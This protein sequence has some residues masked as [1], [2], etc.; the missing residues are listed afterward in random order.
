VSRLV[1]FAVAATL[2]VCAAVPAS[3]A[4]PISALQVE[5]RDRNNRRVRLSEFKGRIVVVDLWASWCPT[6]Q[7]TFPA[8]DAL[9]RTFRACG[10]EVVAVNLDERRQDAETFL[11]G[12]SPDM[13]VA[14]DPRA[15]VLKAFGA[16]GIPSLYIID[17]QGE[18]RHTLSGESP[19]FVA[20]VRRHIVAMLAEDAP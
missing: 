13:L 17:R 2:L 14:F 19:D 8:L 4:S 5:M 6:C 1:K 9:S 11:R 10:V 7:G 12:R 20:Q 16:P 3:T 18:I 15:R